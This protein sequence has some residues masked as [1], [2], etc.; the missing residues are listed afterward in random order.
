MSGHMSRRDYAC[1]TDESLEALVN[2]IAERSWC[3]YVLE[4]S[5]KQPDNRQNKYD[6]RVGLQQRQM[7]RGI[8]GGGQGERGGAGGE[9]GGG[10]ES[11]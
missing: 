7:R 4:R 11:G 10:F 5:H 9:R 2:I 8:K 1:K 6:N 3:G